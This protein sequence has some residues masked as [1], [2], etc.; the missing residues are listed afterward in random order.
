VFWTNA[1]VAFVGA[2]LALRTVP[3]GLRS[4]RPF[5][6]PG[7]A[8]LAAS[9]GL[10]VAAVNVGL[11]QAWLA[12]AALLAASALAFALF[13]RRQRRAPEPLVP[14]PLRRSRVFLGGIF[15][16]LFGFMGSSATSFLMTFYLQTVL[17]L[18]AR[19]AGLTLIAYSIAVI[20]SSPA[21]GRLSDRVSA[22]TLSSAGLL[23]I[24]AGLALLSMLGPAAPVWRV[25]A[26][27]AVVGV[28]VGVFASPNNNAVF[29]AARQE[30][31]GVANGMLGT[32]R[33]LGVT[34][35]V[36]FAGLVLVLGAPG[37]AFPSGP[38]FAAAMRAPLLLAAGFAVLGAVLS[39]LRG[40]AERGAAA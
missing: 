38:D 34:L 29:A 6:V 14:A 7:A 21:S 10:L 4:E 2:A 20:L 18:D 16:A 27:A 36:S 28:G 33:N 26:S 30:D 9:L 24:A 1:P 31:L 37:H 5:D 3:R 11:P 13:A 40:S 12:S 23:V 19:L 25:A 22:A 8:L 32:T 17:G 39:S 15:A 35:G